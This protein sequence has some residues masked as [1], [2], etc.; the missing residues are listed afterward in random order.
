MPVEAKPLFRPDVLRP[1]L[2]GFQL[3]GGADSA[4][5][6]LR[7]WAD[8]LGSPQADSLKEQELLPDFLTDVFRGVLGYTRA[9]DDRDRYTFSR[10]KYVQVDGKYADAVLGDLA[11]A[12]GRVAVVVEGKG[13]RDP[14]DRPFAGRGM[15]AV[16]QAYRYAINLPCDWLVVTSM[17]QTRLYHKGSDQYTY[18][19]FD[20]KALAHDDAQFRRFVFLLGADRVVPPPPPSSFPNRPGRCHLHD[21]LA[22]SERVGRELTREFYVRYANMREDAFEHLRRANPALGPREVLAATQ[23]ILDRVL[24]CAFCEDRGLLPGETI[25][26]AYGH[27]D[28]YN[29]RPVWDNFRGLFRAMNLGN[30]ALNIP[31]YNGGLFADDPVLDRLDVPD[32]V[33]GYFREIAEYDYR[34]P[35][36]ATDDAEPTR[37][38]LVD[39]DILGHI[40]EQSITDLERLKNELD[41]LTKPLAPAEHASRRKKEGAFYTPAFITRYIVG[42]ALG[43]VLADRFDA[44]RRRHAEEAEGTARRVLADPRAYDPAALNGPQRAALVRFWEGWQDELAGVKLLDP[45]CGSGAFLIEAFEQLYLAYLQSNDRLEELRG[46]RTLFDLDRRILQNNLYGVDL[47]GEAAQI[48]RLSLWIKTAQRGKALTSLDH[49]LRVGNSVVADPAVHPRAFG[50]EAAFPEVFE[51]GGFDVVVGNPPY[52]R[53]EWIAPY[54]PYLQGAFKTYHGVA[55]LYVYFY[56]LGM[57]LL[58]PGG[59]LSFVVTNKWLKAAYGEPLRRFFA[60]ESWVESVID[61]GHAKQIFEDADVFPSIIVARKP[62]EAPAPATTRVCA[63]P[64]EQLRIDDLTEQIQAEGFDVER[65]RLTGEA[66]SLEPKA[67]VELMAKLRLRGVPLAEFAGVKPYYGVKTG[68]NEA[69]LIDTPT[70]NALIASDPACEGVIRPYLRGQDIERWSPDWAGLWMIALKS[71][72]DHPWPWADAGE[73]AEDVFRETYPSLH[74]RMKPLQAALTKR[75]DKGRNWW[76]LRSCAYWRAFEGP[77]LFYQ[78]IT[79]KANFCL[80]GRGTLSNNTIYFLPCADPWILAVLNA[81]IGWWFAWRQAQH[82]KDEALRYF[83]SFL[84]GYPIPR[85]S[86]EAREESEALVDRLIQSA[87]ARRD[88]TRGLLDWLRTEHE[89]PVPSTKL[90]S[91]LDLDS[92]AF[93]AEVRKVR[94]KK[95]PLSLAGLKS[96]REEHERTIAPAR[97]LARKALELEHRVSDLVNQAYGLTP[98]EVA[99]MWETAPPRMPVPAPTSSA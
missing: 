26:R 12:P 72:G 21:L 16:D 74:G 65:S 83:T 76:E 43:A 62:T 57:K 84:E 33:C 7:R 60:E 45:S 8:L 61:F 9:V 91:P 98:E 31:A 27:A 15:S 94:G 39:V 75:Q 41:G 22:D 86:D 79:W 3:P 6:I 92:D 44:L 17:R 88:T 13:P 85:P 58:R 52:V 20:I 59:R 51:R 35:H 23:K 71:S 63:I 55:D 49:G 25:A 64:R 18:E 14:L 68:Y 24:F 11:P 93:V 47:N 50:W 10:E 56:E 54:K 90:R 81:P 53:Q 37:G 30:P 36:E 40:F 97:T 87:Q 34:P 96:L 95:K 78:D 67:V 66:W 38:R 73:R 1:R 69:F 80:D 99:L 77:K 42:E 89:I 32:E 48:A 70:R 29:P 5:E 4:R 19:R 46:H 28:P 2:A 82:G